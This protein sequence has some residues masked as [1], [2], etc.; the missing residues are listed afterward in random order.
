[1]NNYSVLGVFQAIKNPIHRLLGIYS[2]NQ[3]KFEGIRYPSAVLKDKYNLAIFP[4]RLKKGS[5]VKVYD[6]DRLIEQ[7]VLGK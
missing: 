3:K 1:M 7:V 6:P 2:T 4:D 5:E